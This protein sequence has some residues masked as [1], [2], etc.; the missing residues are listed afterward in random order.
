KGE[1]TDFVFNE[2][3]LVY[4]KTTNV[5]TYTN[6]KG[7]PQVV[8]LGSLVKANETLTVLSY[9]KATNALSYKDEAGDTHALD[10]G[11]GSVSYNPSTN[12]LTYVNA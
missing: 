10:L 6:S 2:T 4:D 5:L 12:T 9:D 3:S 1:S 8:D 11:T 7:E